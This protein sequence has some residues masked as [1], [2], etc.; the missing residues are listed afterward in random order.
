MYFHLSYFCDITNDKVSGVLNSP[1]A[2]SFEGRHEKVI[3]FFQYKKDI[4][5]C[6]RYLISVTSAQQQ[7]LK[8]VGSFSNFFFFLSLPSLPLS[9]LCFSQCHLRADQVKAY[10]R[11]IS[12]AGVSVCV[13]LIVCVCACMRA[14]KCVYVS[15]HLRRCYLLTCSN[16]ATEAAIVC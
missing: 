12:S 11:L 16:R 14:V 4:N 2:V 13:F 9:F 5:A 15:A 3:Y 7:K 1:K 6:F 8:L 10:C